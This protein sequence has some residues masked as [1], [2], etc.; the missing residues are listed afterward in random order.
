LSIV[1]AAIFAAGSGWIAVMF[2]FTETPAA[3]QDLTW[4]KVI[5][6]ACVAPLILPAAMMAIQLSLLKRKIARTFYVVTS[7]RVLILVDLP[8]FEAATMDLDRI[9]DIQLRTRGDGNGSVTFDSKAELD[10]L[11]RPPSWRWPFGFGESAACGGGFLN[12]GHLG[13]INIA[14]AR[15]VGEL[16][17]RARAEYIGRREV[18]PSNEP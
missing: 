5:W 6:I 17:G 12:A 11:E 1:I 4:L 10:F 7:R 18:K 15:R 13:F 9:Y 16:L 3:M 2:L 8:S 14:D